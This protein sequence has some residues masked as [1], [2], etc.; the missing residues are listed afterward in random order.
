MNFL[1]NTFIFFVTGVVVLIVFNFIIMP[2]YINQRNVIV[3]PDLEGLTL[4]EAENSEI[5]RVPK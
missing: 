1:K 3:I 4:E 5:R 2:I